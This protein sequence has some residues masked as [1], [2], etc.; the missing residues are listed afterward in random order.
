V[1]SIGAGDTQAPLPIWSRKL[2]SSGNTYIDLA[3]E[4]F[5]NETTERERTAVAD[6]SVDQSIR[7]LRLLSSAVESAKSGFEVPIT[8]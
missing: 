2:D 7:L 1:D 6:F 4:L 3:E 5:A 8:E